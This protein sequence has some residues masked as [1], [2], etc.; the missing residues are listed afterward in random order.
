MLLVVLLVYTLCVVSKMLA[1]NA[2]CFLDV[3]HKKAERV[4]TIIR[5]AAIQLANG[6]D[7]TTLLFRKSAITSLKCFWC[8][9]YAVCLELGE[10]GGPVVAV[11][12]AIPLIGRRVTIV[13]RHII[14]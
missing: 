6:D 12:G 13:G 1:T 7:N 2:K 10:A 3:T 5:T 8:N 11:S 9:T 14:V 4:A